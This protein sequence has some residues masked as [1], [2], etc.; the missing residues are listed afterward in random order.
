M[1]NYL[2]PA[3]AKQ[4]SLSLLP[5]STGMKI[6]QKIMDMLNDNPLYKTMGIRVTEAGHGKALSRLKP[7]EKLCW[8]FP[9]QPHGGVLFTQMDA[10]MAWA[11]FSELDEKYNCA[12]IHLDIDY[13]APAK[14]NSFTCSAWVT[15][16]TRR[17]SFVRAEIHD[18][19]RQLLAMGQAT[20]RVISG[21]LK[22]TNIS[23]NGR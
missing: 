9:G 7:D 10:T 5:G 8:P 12:T 14:G 13:T 1:G 15:H 19:N 2:E 17:L 11:V 4:Q 20:F 18:P 23:M 6:T 21:A 22:M 3:E 16:R